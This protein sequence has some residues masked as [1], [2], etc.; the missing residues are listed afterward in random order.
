MS[1][2]GQNIFGRRSPEQAPSRNDRTGRK[3]PV[4]FQGEERRSR[5]TMADHT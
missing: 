5:H 4:R 1:I 3:L 2:F